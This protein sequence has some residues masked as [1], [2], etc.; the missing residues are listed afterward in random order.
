LSTSYHFAHA[1]VRR[2]SN[3]IAKGLRAAD[4]GNPDPDQFDIQHRAYIAAL[5]DAGVKVEILPAWESFPD[6]VFI[7]DSSLCLPKGA[8]VMRPGAP[9]RTGESAAMAAILENYFADVRTISGPGFIEGGD[10]L[11]TDSEII[12]G[13]SDR[14]DRAGVEELSACVADWG[15]VVRTLETPSDVLHFKTACGL[16]DAETILLTEQMAKADFFTNYRTLVIPKG[17]EAAANAIRVNERVF[18]SD[19]FPKTAE[20][21][22]KA[23]YRVIALDTGEAAKVDGGLSCM[24]LRF[25]PQI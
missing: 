15:M 13:L 19:G 22:V 1:V 7:E 12:V 3:S 5:E 23:G 21:L 17:E 14:T 16:L 11:V 20:M 9:S 6:S 10:I 25:S 18:V 2:P 8:V 24:S 4:V